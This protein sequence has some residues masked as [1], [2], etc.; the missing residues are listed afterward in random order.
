[1]GVEPRRPAGA[2]LEGLA[3]TVLPVSLRE[4]S[5]AVACIGGSDVSSGALGAALSEF[6]EEILRRGEVLA[7][8][9]SRIALTSGVSQR[10]GLF[11]QSLVR[12]HKPAVSLEV[13]L[14]FGISALFLCEELQ[15]V[16]AQRHIV[17]DPFQ[18]SAFGNVG[19]ENLRR[20]GFSELVEFHEGPSH[21]ELPRLL[22]RGERID[23][24]FIDGSH[25]FD[26]AFLDF[27]YIDRLLRVG[28]IVAFDDANW[29]GV[30]KVVRYIMTNRPYSHLAS[31]PK[32]L[33]LR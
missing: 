26:C 5:P 23:F 15:K 4:G 1:M 28:G 22:S 29:P 14:A 20:A 27:F 6:A 12:E 30:R 33:S 32:Y 13:G 8:D 25:A 18:S 31:L 24:A 16:G 3:D 10:V 19:V 17:I 7:P 11:L 21:L 2:P 9:G